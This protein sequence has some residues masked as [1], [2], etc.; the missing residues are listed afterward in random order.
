MSSPEACGRTWTISG[1]GYETVVM[2]DI[3]AYV[4]ADAPALKPIMITFD[5]AITTNLHAWPACR[6]GMRACSR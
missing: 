3:I 4:H 6:A 2:A 1:P 5:D